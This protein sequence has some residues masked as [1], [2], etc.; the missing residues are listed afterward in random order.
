MALG[1]RRSD[2]IGAVSL[3]TTVLSFRL[4]GHIVFSID[5]RKTV[6]AFASVKAVSS[7]GRQI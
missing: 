7:N 1:P 6:R 4:V 2:F 3:A 5:E